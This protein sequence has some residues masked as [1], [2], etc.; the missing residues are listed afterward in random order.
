[1]PVLVTGY[2]TNLPFLSSAS[3]KVEKVGCYKFSRRSFKI[4][5]KRS[6]ETDDPG[7]WIQQC[8]SKASAKNL[9]EMAVSL[10]RVKGSNLLLCRKT[11][12]RPDEWETSKRCRSGVGERKTVFV[13]RIQG[14]K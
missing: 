2:T 9:V 8:A 13:Y 3:V 7:D 5:Y 10:K 6:P 14:R 11:K 4:F 1:M 12:G